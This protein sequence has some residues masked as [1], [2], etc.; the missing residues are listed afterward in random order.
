MDNSI[1]LEVIDAKIQVIKT[2]AEE[3]KEL[4]YKF[5]AVSRNAHR[6][7]ASIKMLEINVTDC[8]KLKVSE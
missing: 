2:A 7:L 3:L 1:D 6:I 4:G 8:A 5:P